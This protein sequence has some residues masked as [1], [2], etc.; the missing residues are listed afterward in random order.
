M[1][2]GQSREEQQDEEWRRLRRANYLKLFMFPA[3]VI[4]AAVAGIIW[5]VATVGPANMR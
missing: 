4:L 5:L 2:S 3:M 1:R